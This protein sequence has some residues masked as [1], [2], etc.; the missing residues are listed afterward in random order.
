MERFEV[1]TLRTFEAVER[2]RVEID[3]LNLASRRP[4]PFATF[5]Y[6]KTFL[7][8]DEHQKGGEKLLFLAAF[9][10]AR[11]VGYLPLRKRLLFQQGVPYHRDRPARLA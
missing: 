8:H 4:S 2:L 5:E 3:L 1:K 11:L 6:L 9:D 7:A 10:E